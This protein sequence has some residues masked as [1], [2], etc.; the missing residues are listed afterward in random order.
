MLLDLDGTIVDLNA[1]MATAHGTKI[2]S[3]QGTQYLNLILPE[4]RAGIQEAF[5]RVIGN[6]GVQTLECGCHGGWRESVLRPCFAG[7]GAVIGVAIFSSGATP[8]HKSPEELNPE[9]QRLG[10]TLQR[11]KVGLW[12]FTPATREAWRSREHAE[13]FGYPPSARPGWS[14]EEFMSHVHADDRAAVQLA[15]EHGLATGKGW[16]FECRILRTDAT[17]RWILVKS[18]VTPA[19]VQQP[20][21]VSGIVFDIT[22]RKE[23]QLAIRQCEMKF[24]ALADDAPVLIWTSGLDKRC[25][26]FN[27]PWLAFTGRTF[28]QESG[29]G[30]AEGVHPDDLAHCVETYRTS[31]DSRKPFRMEYRLRRHDGEYRW[32]LDHGVPRHDPDGSF[33]GYVGSCV[34]ITDQKRDRDVA[35]TLGAELR[36]ILNTVPAGVSLTRNRKIVW[37]NPEHDKLFGYL[38]GECTGLGT[39]RFYWNSADRSRLEREGEASLRKG[40]CFTT[41]VEFKRKDG[42]KFWCRLSGRAVNSACSDE[43]S[44]WVLSD[45]TENRRSAELLRLSEAR[46]RESEMRYRAVVEDQTEVIC[47]FTADGT[48]TFVNEVYCRLFGKSNEEL[49]GSK[50]HPHAVSDDLGMIQEKLATLSPENPVVV[51]ENRVHTPA[52]GVRFMQFVNRAFFDSTRRLTEMQSVG[53]DITDQKL[54]E[55]ALRASEEKHRLLFENAGDSLLVVNDAGSILAANAEACSHLGY[56]L[57]ELLNMTLSQIEGAA[58]WSDDPGSSRHSP[59]LIGQ[60]QETVFRQK[61]GARLPVELRSHLMNWD[62]QTASLLICRDLSERKSSEER[63]R[64]SQKMEGIGHLAGG[65]AH[66]FNN[67]LAAMMMSLGL[68]QLSGSDSERKEL[69]QELEESCKRS[70]TLIKQLLAFSR[71]S[72]MNPKVVDLAEVVSVQART[73]R[74]LLGERIDWEIVIDDGL[75]PASADKSLIEQVLLNLC[76]NARDAMSKGGRLRIELGLERVEPERCKSVLDARAGSFLRLSVS[77]TGC[78]MDSNTM[79]LLFEPFFTTKEVGRGTGLGLA[80]SRGIIQQHQG[81]IEVDS[82]PGAGSTFRVYL[83]PAGSDK[84]ARTVPDSGTDKPS[85]RWTILLVEDDDRL[86]NLT[87]RTLKQHGYKVYEAVDGAAAMA[88]WAGRR[89]EIDLVYTDM[90]LPGRMSG[91]QIVERARVDRPDVKAIITSGYTT[92]IEEIKKVNTPSIIYLLKPASPQ[93]LLDSIARLLLQKP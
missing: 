57:P 46:L 84:P 23:A 13:I 91:L 41:E 27:K 55:A 56:S 51:I 92:E 70:A 49:V 32:L 58:V 30:W 60:L 9:Q 72:V 33:V 16:S 34:D 85:G 76:L 31:F 65:M 54:A 83:P 43:G 61:G 62:G 19:S 20:R 17:L 90:V 35:A 66:E 64:Q 89:D 2:E 15:I 59:Q 45:I 18:E 86:R 22:E 14:F 77:D 68:A 88:I 38:P 28:E 75:P 93:V 78:G 69:L 3:L 29:D 71:Q 26:F 42:C 36:A 81:W 1:A 39:E 37:S 53:R 11:T 21:C 5:N 52:N 44:I 40:E 50:W 24:A 87:N 47:R 80:T 74:P 7:D 4:H 73:L 82:A 12:E 25:D 8:L 6:G 48:L 79:K 63:L 10:F 67:I